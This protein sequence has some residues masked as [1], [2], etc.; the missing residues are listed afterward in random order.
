METSGF[1]SGYAKISERNVL[2]R[3]SKTFSKNGTH[4][5][6]ICGSSDN[7]PEIEDSSVHLAITSPPY[8]NAK[9]YSDSLEGDLGNIDC[10][11][12]WL[13]EIQKVW[14]E[15]YR[16]LDHGRKFFINIMN[17]PVKTD[18]TF[19]TL[20]LVGKT[21]D[22]C[23]DVGFVFKREIIWHKTN[24][25][26]A[27]FGSYPYPGGILINNMHESILEFQKPDEPGYKKYKHISDKIKAESKLDK[28][29]WLTIKNTDVWLMKPEKSGSGR[30]HIAPFP[31]ELPS[32]LIKA[33]SYIGETVFDPFAGSGTT[34]IASADL[35]RNS[36]VA[37]INKDFVDIA[38]DRIVNLESFRY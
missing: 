14:Q 34:S 18:K 35:K 6:F 3:K 10:L 25:V 28:D 20:N 1:I 12:T 17:L 30:E 15:T 32:R 37:E 4:H 22:L 21:I 29:F 31:K 9:T 16:V 23:E 13:E 2:H 27:H 26:K 36:I 38:V 5:T 11:D 33:F 8:F 24:G 19:R 7:L